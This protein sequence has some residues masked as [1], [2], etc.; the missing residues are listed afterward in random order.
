MEA[1]VVHQVGRLAFGVPHCKVCP[2][3]LGQS[4]PV[5][6]TARGYALF[7]EV[8]ELGRG[9][10]TVRVKDLKKLEIRLDDPAAAGPS[11]EE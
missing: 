2:L 3:F 7:C 6:A 8:C 1:G 11:E 9:P 10:V 5:V 4:V